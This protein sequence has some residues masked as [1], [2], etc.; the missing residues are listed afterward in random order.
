M[1]EKVGMKLAEW[2]LRLGGQAVL[3]YMD[4]V[5]LLNTPA[6]G[7]RIYTSPDGRVLVIDPVTP[8]TAEFGVK[9]G[10]RQM[11]KRVIVQV[12]SFGQ[13][14]RVELDRAE[15]VAMCGKISRYLAVV[16]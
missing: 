12:T 7:H 5:R 15:A 11:R 14:S 1:R 9:T 2:A 4:K 16:D 6:Y 13:P 3:T 10:A 8:E